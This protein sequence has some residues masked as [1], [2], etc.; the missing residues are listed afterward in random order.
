MIIAILFRIRALYH[1]NKNQITTIKIITSY[2]FFFAKRFTLIA[3]T[4]II[5]YIGN[6]MCLAYLVFNPYSYSNNIYG[7]DCAKYLHLKW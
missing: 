3:N 1:Y 5:L 6:Y 2:I 7:L 4:L